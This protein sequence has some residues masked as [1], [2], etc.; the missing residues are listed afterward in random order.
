MKKTLFVLVFIVGLLPFANV[1]SAQP[2]FAPGQKAYKLV[3]SV[4]RDGSIVST[5]PKEVRLTFASPVKVKYASIFDQRNREYSTGK[6]KVNP[7][8]ARQVIVTL[9]REMQPGTYGVEWQV[10][11]S[12]TADTEDKNL[13]RVGQIYFA[14]QSLSPAPKSAGAGLVEQVSRETLPNWLAFFGM[15]VSFGGTF[16]VQFI[17]RKE[18][19]HRRWQYWQI[20]VYFLTAAAALVLFFVRK[21]ALPEVTLNELA[22]LPIGWVPLVQFFVFTLLFG[23]AFTRWTLPFAGAMLVL[24]AWV[25]RSYSPEYGSG[26][27]VAMD[28]IHLLALSVWFGGLFALVVLA[29]KDGRWQWFK[30]KGTEFSRWALVSMILLAL[31]GFALTV[32]Y[33]AS[34]NDFI[35]SIWG[36]TILV[37]IA[38][39]VCIAL[40]GVLQ[41]RTMRKAN[42]KRVGWLVRWAKWS[43]SLGVVVL[44]LSGALVNFVPIASEV[45]GIPAKVTKQGSTAYATITP[46]VSGFNDVTIRFEN[47]PDIQDVYVRFSE[48]PEYHALNRAFDLGDGRY[49]ISGDQLRRP[50]AAY[51]NV[52]AVTK[53]G[54]TIVYTFPPRGTAWCDI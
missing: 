34:W 6:I 20:P 36:L 51:I 17:V 11:A 40:L 23:I 35:R 54:R 49:R 45:G 7:Q 27:A 41:L 46:F 50:S 43:I 26:I 14:V 13:K 8:D 37:K 31:T 22:A 53:D 4:P 42:E 48:L 18:D 3:A 24:N 28:S 33:A 19:V 52:E 25:G 47:V 5:A 30:E 9:A 12:D 15:A 21:A 16:F 2:E 1:A 44:L 32:D 39:V 10:E 38:L 29:P